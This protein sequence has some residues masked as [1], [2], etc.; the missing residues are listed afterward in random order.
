LRVPGGKGFQA[1]RTNA[2]LFQV[3]M[4]L[5]VLKNQKRAQLVR[6]VC[7]RKMEAGSEKKAE[8]RKDWRG[9]RLC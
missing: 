2:E 5:L 4:S 3:V 7:E 1:E 6:E 9:C 8:T